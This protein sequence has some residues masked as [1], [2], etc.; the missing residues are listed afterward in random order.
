[1]D[2]EDQILQRSKEISTDAYAMSVG[3]MIS[4]YKDTSWTFIRSF[5]VSSVGHLVRSPASSSPC[6]WESRCHL[7]S[8][9]KGQTAPGTSLTGCRGSRRSSN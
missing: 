3:E 9:R 4:L 1:M 2:L 8:C 6:C 7:S 5:S